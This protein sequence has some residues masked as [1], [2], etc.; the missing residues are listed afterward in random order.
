V[1]WLQLFFNPLEVCLVVF[2][3][4]EDLSASSSLQ[5]VFSPLEVC[6]ALFCIQ[7]DLSAIAL[8]AASF[9]FLS[10]PYK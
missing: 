9:F 6:L 7:E 8:A 2:C 10:L 5:L 4:K 3:T 1:L